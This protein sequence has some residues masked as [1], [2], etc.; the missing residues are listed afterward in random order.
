MRESEEKLLTTDELQQ[1]TQRR[2]QEERENIRLRIVKEIEVINEQLE[3]NNREMSRLSTVSTQDFHAL[4]KDLS[5]VIERKNGILINLESELQRII[6]IQKDKNTPMDEFKKLISEKKEKEGNIDKLKKEIQAEKGELNKIQIEINNQEQS[7]QKMQLL[8]NQKHRLLLEK[9]EK[10]KEL[11]DLDRQQGGNKRKNIEFTI[12]H[13][14]KVY[15]RNQM[16]R[17]INF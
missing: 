7:K 2:K 10:E 5:F 16:P 1:E 15:N 12:Y 17:Y 9:E 14:I 8:Q 13:G 3:Q 4:H 6:T 11:H